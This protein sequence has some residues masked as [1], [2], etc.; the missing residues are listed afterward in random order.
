MHRPLTGWWLFSSPHRGGGIPQHAYPAQPED[1]GSSAARR[2]KHPLPWHAQNAVPWEA[3][4]G[5]SRNAIAEPL[6]MVLPRL[7]G[8]S[9][10]S[11]WPWR[12]VGPA[13]EYSESSY[14]ASGFARHCTPPRRPGPQPATPGPAGRCLGLATNGIKIKKKTNGKG[15]VQKRKEH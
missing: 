10:T 15:K 8:G 13:S 5:T 11:R 12:Q 4:A 9:A 6:C 14:P 3:A 2:P 1:K 7:G